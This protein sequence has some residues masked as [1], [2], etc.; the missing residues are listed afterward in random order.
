MKSQDRKDARVLLRHLKA[1]ARESAP[2]DTAHAI[3]A[4]ARRQ[5]E[6]GEQAINAAFANVRA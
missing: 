3:I 5:I 1:A 6:L 4:A 2:P